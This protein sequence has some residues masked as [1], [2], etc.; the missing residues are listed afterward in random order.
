MFTIHPKNLEISVEVESGKANLVFK[1]GK[2]PEKMGFLQNSSKFPNG[3]F[4]LHLLFTLCTLFQAFRLVFVTVEM[5]VEMEHANPMEISIRG[6][7]AS[8]VLQL[9]TIRFFRLNSKQPLSPGSL[10][11][12]PKTPVKSVQTQMERTVPLEI[13]FNKR[14]TFRG[15]PLQ[16]VGTET[17]F[18]KPFDLAQRFSSNI[19]FDEQCLNV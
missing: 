8:H 9:L 12:Q 19:M 7:D 5:S 17:L 14:T 2:F 18:L 11:V 3:K 15:T 6:F 16:P 13:F 10:S 1:N 4:A